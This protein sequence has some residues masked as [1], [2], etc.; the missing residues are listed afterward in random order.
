MQQPVPSTKKPNN[1]L[2]I[3]IIKAVNFAG[4]TKFTNLS[5][6]CKFQCFLVIAVNLTILS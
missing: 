5:Y 4:F 2:M 3:I 6:L 1:V